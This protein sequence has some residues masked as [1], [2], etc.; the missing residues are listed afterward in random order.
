VMETVSG[1]L[2]GTPRILDYMIE[3]MRVVPL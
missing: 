1:Q 3:S 2:I